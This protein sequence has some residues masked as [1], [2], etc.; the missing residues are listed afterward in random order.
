MVHRCLQNCSCYIINSE[1]AVV[2]SL[3]ER[4]ESPGEP[5]HWSSGLPVSQIILFNKFSLNWLIISGTL[6]KISLE[7][8][9]SLEMRVKLG[10]KFLKFFFTKYMYMYAP[11]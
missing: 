11:L 3:T 7:L 9:F 1:T 5:G 6:G 8:P 4:A 2:T 10:A